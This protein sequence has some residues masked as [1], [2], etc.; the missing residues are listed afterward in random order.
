MKNINQRKAGAILSYINLAISCVIPL[1]YTPVMLN[2]LGQKEYGLYALSNSV[3]SYLSLLNLGM[4]TAIIRYIIRYRATGEIQKVRQM[5]GLFITIYSVLAVLVCVGGGI[6]IHVSGDMFG[7]GLE[8]Q[9]IEK[10]RL[11]IAVMTISMAVSFPL[12]TFAS[13]TVAYEE[14]LYNKSICVAETILSPILNLIVLY[15]G[16]GSLGLV[17][18]GLLI[19]LANGALY[20]MYCW[21]RLKIYPVFRNMPLSCLKE[22]VGFCAFVFLSSIVDMLYW[23]TDKVLIGAI[24]GSAFV[25]VYNIGGTFNAMLQSMSSA[26]SSVFAPQVNMM[27]AQQA[28]KTELSALLIRVGR[29][30]YLIIS[31]VLSGYI[32]FG[33]DFI[34]L[35]AGEEYKDA[36]YVALLTMIPLAIPLIQNIAFT[37]I[38][39][40]N[41]HR[42][43]S[44]LYAVIAVIN[45]VST[46]LILP[47]WGIIG[48]A[49]CT[50]ASFVIGN[51]IIINIYYYFVIGL[52]VISFWKNIAQQTI[53]P[54]ILI[55]FAGALVRSVL[56]MA[57]LWWFLLWV[58][59]YSIVFAG[60]TWVFSMNRYEKELLLGLVRKICSPFVRHSEN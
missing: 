20:G 26:I 14:Y 40:E 42:F 15:A 12:G 44:V 16:H 57:S 46:Y 21:K 50:A 31:L 30:Q 29:I 28:K 39:A 6:L 13:V 8:A 27:V 7:R 60:L 37:T 48:A 23:A 59:M 41:K 9:E 52:D 32:V 10:L 55:V 56:P 22:L 35:W 18:V 4:G 53:V 11:L 49:L 54:G 33:Q 25:A 47:H 3:I 5:F 51:G 34:R 36:Y 45:V 19:Q 38:L 58:V 1:L 24:L 43:R 17:L 2:V